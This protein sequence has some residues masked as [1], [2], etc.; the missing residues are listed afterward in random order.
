MF[1]THFFPSGKS[2]DQFKKKNNLAFKKTKS[3]HKSQTYRPF[4]KRF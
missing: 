1:N 4:Q 3:K 2:Y